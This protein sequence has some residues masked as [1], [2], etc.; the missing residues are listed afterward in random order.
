MKTTIKKT[1]FYGSNYYQL[2]S[3]PSNAQLNIFYNPEVKNEE[4]FIKAIAEYDKLKADNEALN[5]LLCGLTPGGSEFVNDP[6]YCVKYVKKFED[7]QHE[8]IMSLIVENKQLIYQKAELLGVLKE[9]NNYWES[10]NFSRDP[11]LWNR[12][13]ETIQKSETK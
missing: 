12:I 2:K 1:V 7:S 10:G 13:K 3:I 9:L 11:D 4:Y 6:E 5:K 8:L